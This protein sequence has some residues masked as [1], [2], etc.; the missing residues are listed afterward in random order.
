MPVPTNINQVSYAENLKNISLSPLASYTTTATNNNFLVVWS[1]FRNRYCHSDWFLSCGLYCSSLLGMSLVG[2]MVK[3]LKWFINSWGSV[4]YILLIYLIHFLFKSS[5]LAKVDVS[6]KVNYKTCI[7]RTSVRI[8]L[9][10]LGNSHDFVLCILY[11]IH[12]V[13]CEHN[14]TDFENIYI[15][16]SF[17]QFDNMKPIQLKKK[18]V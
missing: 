1:S 6:Y 9:G 11:W 16:F 8:S 5:N 14:T 12:L 13:V 15:Y 3:W 10:Y 7:S 4:T 2:K 18:R 17:T